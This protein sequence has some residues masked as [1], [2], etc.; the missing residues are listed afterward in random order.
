MV[1]GETYLL[2]KE[3]KDIKDY[4]MGINEKT[5]K[6]DYFVL[7]NSDNVIEYVYNKYYRNCMNC[8]HTPRPFINFDGYVYVVYS[9][10]DV[11]ILPHVFRGGDDI[12]YSSTKI[13]I[14]QKYSLSEPETID[15]LGIKISRKYIEMATLIGWIK[16]LD[17]LKFPGNKNKITSRI[18]L[19]DLYAV[20]SNAKIKNYTEE[21]LKWWNNSGLSM[22]NYNCDEAL[23]WWN[24]S[25]FQGIPIEHSRDPNIG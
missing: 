13:N 22:D 1:Q 4:P 23:E 21:G 25:C 6:G 19:P 2:I 9:I 7:T 18:Y 5:I 20:Y 11:S 3:H 12:K 16:I 17:L 24:N 14:T 8:P 15:K 10:N